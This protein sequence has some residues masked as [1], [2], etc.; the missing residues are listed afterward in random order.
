MITW[1]GSFNT[2]IAEVF[3]DDE[4]ADV[5]YYMRRRPRIATDE[6]TGEPIFYY[7]LIARDVQ[8]AFAS[9]TADHPPQYQIGMLGLHVDLGLS[10]AELEEVKA[11]CREQMAPTGGGL[12]RLHWRLFGLGQP[13]SA[14]PKL[15]AITTWLDG[16]VKVELGVPDGPTFMLKSSTE[17][18]PS[19]SGT[20]GASFAAS[21]GAEGAQ[22][23][24]EALGGR[25]RPEDPPP[26]AT[27]LPN[28][29]Y[30]LKFAVRSPALEVTVIAHGSSVYQELRETTRVTE[31]TSK[32]TWTYPQI[33]ELSKKL[34]SN[35]AIEIVWKDSGLPD[36]SV[37][38]DTEARA[39]IEQSLISLV[40]DKI[41]EVF[42]TEYQ[43]KGLQE[44]DLGDDPFAHSQ[45]GSG[46]PGNRLWL[47]EY[48]EEFVSDISFKLTRT[49]NFVLRRAPNMVLG[50]DAGVDPAAIAARIKFL[51]VGNP[52]V[53]VLD[54]AL[55]TNAD[56]V[57][58]NIANI[59]VHARYDQADALTGGQAI[60]TTESFVFRTGKETFRFLTRLARDRDHRLVDL[61]DVTAGINYIGRS[62]SPPPIEL[63]GLWGGR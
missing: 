46:K 33:S 56:F 1:F 62:Q 25:R 42:F 27:A 43:V 35:R 37:G 21:F 41:V 48:K 17:A 55:D 54:V 22:L 18:R 20:N 36:A 44:G 16:T 3:R 4:R 38:G 61:Y 45:A 11:A 40:T 32:G 2:P 14:E 60:Q 23:M 9:G 52:E 29:T 53:Q 34:L 12:R 26:T 15:S 49:Q 31:S 59:T 58:D 57:N 47:R 24:F 8:L 5:F 28:V 6:K 39:Q 30:D 13:A 19:L 63:R 7:H 50:F 10:D 51:D